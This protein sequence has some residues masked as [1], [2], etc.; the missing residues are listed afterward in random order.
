MQIK[1]SYLFGQLNR[2]GEIAFSEEGLVKLAHA[3]FAELTQIGLTPQ[4]VNAFTGATLDYY[5]RAD[6]FNFAESDQILYSGSLQDWFAIWGAIKSGIKSTAKGLSYATKSMTKSGANKIAKTGAKFNTIAGKVG[7]N[8]VHVGSGQ[9][10]GF[11]KRIGS[12]FKT[13]SQLSKQVQGNQVLQ[14]KLTAARKAS[15]NS[16]VKKEMGITKPQNNPK[17]NTTDTSNPKPDK[18]NTTSSQTQNVT[19]QPKITDTIKQK[20]QEMQVKAGQFMSGFKDKGG[21]VMGIGGEGFG[22]WAS[23]NKAQAATAAIGTA[24][25][26]Y[27]AYRMLRGPKQN[28]QQNNVNVNVQR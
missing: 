28:P 7:A 14:N 21:K 25:A 12:G 2:L 24:A 10:E 22:K 6:Q 8:S 17:P 5:Q 19:K 9:S 3:L 13:G 1:T 11:F 23:Q 27:G 15:A 26:A 20:N 16:W 4:E 18:P